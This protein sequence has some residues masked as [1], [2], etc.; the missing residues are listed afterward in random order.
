MWMPQ[1]LESLPESD[2]FMLRVAH[3][4]VHLA[5]GT[6]GGQSNFKGDLNDR[7]CVSVCTL[8]RK[9]LIAA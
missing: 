8:I 2:I 5:M 1:C 6:A 4:C 7:L 3:T 9:K